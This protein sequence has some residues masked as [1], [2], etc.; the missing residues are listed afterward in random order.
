MTFSTDLIW[1]FLSGMFAFNSLPHL[2]S[3]VIGNKHMTPFSKDSSAV[4]N[5]GWGFLNLAS[6]FL[7][8]SLTT[9][10]LSF[11][12]TAEGVGAFLVGG[13]ALSLMAANMFSNP[14]SKM[15]WWK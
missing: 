3:G 6:A 4:L 9:G 7:I 8:L 13:L 11:P 10:N 1:Y 12:S 14:N 5:V 2:I 15:P